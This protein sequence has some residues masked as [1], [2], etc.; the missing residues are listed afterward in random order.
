M[1]NGTTTKNDPVIP[2][3]DVIPLRTE[4]V[5][6]TPDV[7]R[8]WLES[9]AAN[10]NLSRANMES[11]AE[12]MD[13]G[14][15]HDDGSPIRFNRSGQLIDG[16]HRL[17]AIILTGTP[18]TFLVV[19]GVP[20]KA[21]TTLDTGKSRSRGDVLKIHDPQLVNVTNV[22]ATVGMMIRWTKGYRNH[23]LRTV[24]VNNDEVVE[25]YE[26]YRDDVMDATRHGGRLSK[27]T[28]AGSPMAFALCFWLFQMLNAEDAE[29]FWDRLV[30]GSGLEIGSP[31]YALRELL[32]REARTNTR[33]RLRSDVITALIIKAWNAY[34][35]GEEIRLL[36]F[37][38]G[39]AH[40][41]K[42]PE[43][44]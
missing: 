21:M 20:D 37:K 30:D 6:V 17:S 2:K 28:A 42:F 25:F 5:E 22:A 34:R 40:P 12:A 26:A 4:M 27:A 11:L 1:P 15:W 19:W 44:V 36:A 13:D 31:V 38:T 7:A 39:G 14:R 10:R 24:P 3:E 23:Y 16:Q 29:F 33:E 43:P 18:R 9:M 32:A 8:E 35:R 41:E